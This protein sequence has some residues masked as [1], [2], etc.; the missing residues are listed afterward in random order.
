VAR[1]RSDQP[2]AGGQRQPQPRIDDED[3]IAVQPVP[4][5]WRQQAHAVV[6][7]VVQKDV[8]VD[9]DVRQRQQP[10]DAERRARIASTGRASSRG[11][12]RRRR[13][14]STRSAG[15]S[16]RRCR[17]SIPVETRMAG[18]DDAKTSTSRSG[19]L[20]AIISVALPQRVRCFRPARPARRRRACD[21][22]IQERCQH[23]GSLTADSSAV[24]MAA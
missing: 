23:V 19:R 17:A 18:V 9:A 22:V 16:A 11:A 14:P 2:H 7:Q 8:R 12:R 15:R 20:A 5:E 13:P 6:I 1:R 24:R 21:K 4:V 3:R 10:A